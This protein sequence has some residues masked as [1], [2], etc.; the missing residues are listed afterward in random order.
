[1]SINQSSSDTY[2]S[3]ATDSDSEGPPQPIY[4]SESSS[5]SYST[6]DEEFEESPRLTNVSEKSVTH[7][8][9]AQDKL[10]RQVHETQHQPPIIFT[11]AAW[12][13]AASD[14]GCPEPDS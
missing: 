10:P 1:M 7:S 9:D 6:D 8:T 13:E 4:V 5:D 2:A 14:T 12:N 3:Y 11:D